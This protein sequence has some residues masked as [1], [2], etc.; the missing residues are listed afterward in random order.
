MPR[1]PRVEFAGAMY[2]VMSRGDKMEPIFVDDKDRLVFLQTLGEVCEKS[3]W[4]VHTF[5]FMRNHYHLLIET[6]RPT[7]VRGMQYLNSTYTR[8]YNVRHRTYGH[9][10]QGRY[11]ALLVDGESGNYFLTV[12]DYIHLNPARAGLIKDPYDIWKYRWSSAAWLAGKQRAK[13]DWLEW[14]KLYGE[15]SLEGWNRRN[16]LEFQNYLERRVEEGM[17]PQTLRPLRWGWCFGDAVF[18][19]E[20][21]KRVRDLHRKPRRDRENWNDPVVDEMEEDRASHLLG[22]AAEALGQPAFHKLK[23]WERLVVARWVRSRANV[24]VAGLAQMLGMKTRGGLANG[25]HLVG[26]RLMEKDRALIKIW[27]KLDAI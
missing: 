18:K 17:D 26:K 20:M 4:R 5:T 14:Q 8:R 9:V 19:D 16:R 6:R 13:P 1:A 25:I 22:K 2:H 23:G 21:K 11:K 3:G 7:L 27:R 24:P 10:F 15:L 12:S